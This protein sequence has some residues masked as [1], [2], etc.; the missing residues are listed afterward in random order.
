MAPNRQQRRHAEIPEEIDADPQQQGDAAAVP[1][2]HDQEEHDELR[3]PRDTRFAISEDDV[4]A[5]DDD[6][7]D[8]DV[9]S[10]KY[11]PSLPPSYGEATNARDPWYKSE[12]ALS[13]WHYLCIAGSKIASLVAR[14]WPT[15]RFAQAGFFIAGLWIIVI[16]TG[17]T[18]DKSARLSW[19]KGFDS[20]TSLPPRPVSGDGH[21]EALADWSLPSCRSTQLGLSTYCTRKAQF[22]LTIPAAA[23]A[24]NTSEKVFIFVDPIRPAGLSNGRGKVPA[25][26]EVREDGGSGAEVAVEIIAKYEKEVEPLLQRANV[27][28][29]AAGLADRGVGIYT[30]PLPPHFS[31]LPPHIYPYPLL[32]FHIIAHVSPQSRISTLNIDGANVGV[33]F[34][35]SVP[36]HPSHSNKRGLED[37]PL[38]DIAPLRHLRFGH[39]IGQHRAEQAQKAQKRAQDAAS[40]AFYGNVRITVGQGDLSFGSGL[41]AMGRVWAVTDDGSIDIGDDAAMTAF[42]VHLEAK[43]GPIR[44]GKHTRIE[45]EDVVNMLSSSVGDV[46]IMDNAV[47]SATR[48]TIEARAGSVSA[49]GSSWHSNHTLVAKALRE[50]TAQIGISAPYRPA[51]GVG[52]EQRPW[53]FVNATSARGDV[54]IVLGDHPRGVALRGA[55][56]A[57]KA[58]V[59]VALH[60]EYVGS[61]HV[62]GSTPSGS[63]V[64]APKTLSDG[65]QGRDRVYSSQDKSTRTRFESV[66]EVWW[67][68]HDSS[69]SHPTGDDWG[70]IDVAAGGGTARLSFDS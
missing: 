35:R 13:L 65:D 15:S 44:V 57:N 29:M 70:S 33:A 66:G 49:G 59:D 21:M 58:S 67:K 39:A 34:Y 9:A 27:G 2:L 3:R 22:N 32:S 48:L 30:W 26:V 19:S 64:T 10:N 4:E 41:H 47:V 68:K 62:V 28:L 23:D 16:V 63:R 14:Y 51:L 17:P 45:A 56:S 37:H 18:W 60:R 25:T 7:D 52:T 69:Q 1:L 61:F 43:K 5:G 20:A 54:K 38:L 8:L 55:F 50:V 24:F 42:E 53:V 46:T 12:F 31:M 40:H 6:G 36:S 11:P